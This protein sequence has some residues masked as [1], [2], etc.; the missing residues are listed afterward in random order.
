MKDLIKEILTNNW[1][2]D[3]IFPEWWDLPVYH[4]LWLMPVLLLQTPIA[5][6]VFL[7]K[8]L[9]REKEDYLKRK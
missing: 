3:G 7:F 8:E 1:G 9:R 6:F 5:I 4:K 2:G